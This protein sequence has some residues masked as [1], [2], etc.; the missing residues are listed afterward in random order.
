[1]NFHRKEAKN[2]KLFLFNLFALFASWRFNY[3]LTITD[4]LIFRCLS[5]RNDSGDFTLFCMNNGDDT[6]FY[7]QSQIISDT[8]S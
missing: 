6:I 2:A 3:P 7:R 8:P 4:S 5:C 1:M